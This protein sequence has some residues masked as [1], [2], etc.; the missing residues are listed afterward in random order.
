MFKLKY[1]LLG[2]LLLPT[3]VFA[4][5]VQ[6]GDTPYGLWGENWRSELASY[7]IYD[8]TKLPI[9]L[10]IWD[11]L[12]GA[13]SKTIEW[14]SAT[15]NYYIGTGSL[16]VGTS[17]PDTGFMGTGDIF[18][19]YGIKPIPSSGA[20]YACGADVAGMTYYDSSDNNFYGCNASSWVQMNN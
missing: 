12:L 13:T 15:N 1:I 16:S 8:P 19:S 17:S 14:N 3:G 4:Y 6:S 20:P 9:G 18:A 10:E 11:E 5:T 7:D 2:L